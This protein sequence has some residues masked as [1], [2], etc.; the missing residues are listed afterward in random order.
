MRSFT[1]QRKHT[2]SQ[3]PPTL[4]HFVG[5]HFKFSIF[6][7]FQCSMLLLPVRHDHNIVRE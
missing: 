3:L 4:H 7:T 2:A 6:I 5:S 1:Y